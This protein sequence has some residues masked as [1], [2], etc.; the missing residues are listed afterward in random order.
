MRFEDH[1]LI[2]S[3]DKNERFFDY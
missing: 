3:G 1:L 2:L